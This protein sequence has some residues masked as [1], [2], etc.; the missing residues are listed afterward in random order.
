MVLNLLRVPDIQPTFI[1][2]KSFHQFQAYSA[3]PEMLQSILKI[4]KKKF[5]FFRIGREKNSI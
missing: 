1:L 4:I 3:M 2:E 5:Y